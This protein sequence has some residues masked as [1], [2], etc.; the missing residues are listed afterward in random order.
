MSRPDLSA[1]RQSISSTLGEI[2]Q[3]ERIMREAGMDVRDPDEWQQ[4]KDIV[5]RIERRL[6]ANVKDPVA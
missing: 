6:A 2:V 5:A 1:A 4:L 3:G